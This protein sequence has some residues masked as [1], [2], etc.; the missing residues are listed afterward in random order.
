MEG[1][2]VSCL[3][4]DLNEEWGE[5]AD[6]LVRQGYKGWMRFE[7]KYISCNF[8]YKIIFKHFRY[9]L[10]NKYNLFK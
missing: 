1:G 10:S 4:L 9:S 7:V 2:G 5:G 8:N 6:F 3:G